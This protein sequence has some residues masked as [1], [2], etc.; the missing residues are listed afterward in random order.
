MDRAPENRC[1]LAERNQVLGLG[2][3]AKVFIADRLAI[4]DDALRNLASLGF[5]DAAYLI[6]SYSFRIYF[7]F[8][9]YSI[10]AIGLGL[11]F[12]VRIPKNFEEPY[13]S[14]NPRDFW[15]RWHVSLSNWLRD[16]VYLKLGGRQ[17]Y[18]RNI[19][20]VFVACGIWHGAGYH[21]IVWGAAHAFLVL[22]YRAT[23]PVWDRLPRV[24]QVALTFSLVSLVWPLFF[25]DIGAYSALFRNIDWEL[26]ASTLGVGAWATLAGASILVFGVR[27][28]FWLF[29]PPAR[30]WPIINGPILHAFVLF[31]GLLGTTW[32][33]TF[34]Y[35]RF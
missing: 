30:L 24:L 1:G 2:L 22:G 9:G 3:A 29:D 13:L 23:S 21:F 34:I 11:M 5:I 4:A 25:L 26:Q 16:Y 18:V 8:W 27:E 17:R 14:A 10:M 35:F 19:V 33:R 32:S 20:F 15:R 7:D 31:A 6:V 12:G 28:R